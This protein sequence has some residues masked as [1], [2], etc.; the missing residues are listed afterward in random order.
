MDDLHAK[1]LLNMIPEIGPVKSNRLLAYFGTG[2]AEKIFNAT[3]DEISAIANVSKSVA[4]KIVHAATVF[5]VDKEFEKAANLGIRIV[6]AGYDGYPD[7]LKLITDPPVVLY[8][9]GE[10]KQTD[11]FS[12]AIVGT[13]RPTS[14]GRMATE[15]LAAELVGLGVTII[16]GLA[17]GI[18]TYAHW[19]AI[20]S[21]GRT[22]AVLGNGIGTHYP[23]ENRGLEEKIVTTGSGAIVSEFPVLSTPEKSNFPQRNRLISALS[24]G[25]VVIEGEITS[26]ALITAKC[27]LDQGKDVFALPGNIFSKYSQG[28]HYLLK[29]GAKLVESAADVVQEINSLAEWVSKQ[30]KL[31]LNERNRKGTNEFIL[32]N[33]VEEEI[34]SCLEKEPQGINIDELLALTH[35]PVNTLSEMLLSLE[36]KGKVRSFPGKVYIKS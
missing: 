31:Q 23:P 30:T 15:K 32:L 9:L 13:R 26:G 24:L 20:K 3:S 12:I 5:D 10:V 16:S 21:K 19:S 7:Q 25:T 14:Y 1:V 27:A 18:D 2:T 29:Q 4:D 35:K 8:V 33:S 22:I 36:L 11:L 28:P 34:L 17:R 6:V